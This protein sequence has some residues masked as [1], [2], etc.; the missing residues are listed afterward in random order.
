MKVEGKEANG[1]RHE[2]WRISRGGKEVK[3]HV[4]GIREELKRPQHEESEVWEESV[5]VRR[6]RGEGA[7]GFV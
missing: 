5:R 7:P 6:W 4:K 1:Q 3:G 2:R